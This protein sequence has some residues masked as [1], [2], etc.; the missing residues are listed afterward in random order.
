VAAWP[1]GPID[2]PQEDIPIVNLALSRARFFDFDSPSFR[3]WHQHDMAEGVGHGLR[4]GYTFFEL[5]RLTSQEVHHL[6]S[7]DVL[8]VPSRWATNVVRDSG[9]RRPRL[10]ILCPGVDTTTFGPHVAPAPVRSA[11]PESTIFL[12]VGKWSLNKGHDALREA[13]DIAFS[14]EDDV[15]L[16]MACFNPV[17]TPRADGPAESLQWADWYM[18]CRMGEAGRIH[19]VPGRLPSQADVS[20][21]MAAADCGVFPARGEGWNLE[22]AEMLAM[23]KHVVLTDHSAHTEF[24]PV[25][26]AQMVRVDDLEP[27]HDGGFFD[28]SA[29]RWGGSPGRW[30]KLGLGEIHRFAD[31]MR[32]IHEEKRASRLTRNVAGV[33][34]F[35]TKF[36]W[37]K[38]A[39]TVVAA[40]NG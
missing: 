5:D 29:S 4:V 24:G 31:C 3:L 37:E 28:A 23:G 32:R 36:T 10:G 6:N 13:F 34:A 11:N 17:C 15:L 38:T 18:R 25:S 35:R 7:L 30:A 1:I 16:V 33:N 19:I 27:A 26:G 21:L 40:L 14:P 9:V 12:N 22:A 39:E 2:V 8:F 20:S